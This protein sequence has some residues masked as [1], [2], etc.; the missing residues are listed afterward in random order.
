MKK[1]LVVMVVLVS[2]MGLAGTALAQDWACMVGCEY[3]AIK[4]VCYDTL[5]CKGEARGACALGCGPCAPCVTYS[6]KWLSVA[7]CLAVKKPVVEEKSL[8]DDLAK[9]LRLV[10][11]P[12]GPVCGPVAWAPKA[13]AAPKAAKKPAKK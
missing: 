6:G 9:T 4:T 8:V 5:L 10:A 2:C 1:S 11:L 12:C 13:A 7:K 3:P